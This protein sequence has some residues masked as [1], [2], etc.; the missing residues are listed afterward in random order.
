MDSSRRLHRAAG[1]S[2]VARP[3]PAVFFDKDGTLVV[4]VPYNVDPA[5]IRLAPGAP[6]G[7]PML[8]RLRL[9]LVVISNQSGIGSGR[10]GADALPA[11]SDRL[12][13]LCS[14]L[15]ASLTDCYYCPHAPQADGTPACGC[16][17]PRP[18]MLWAAARRHRIDLSE[19]W[20]VGD[21]LDDIEAAHRAGCRA[22]LIDNG[23]ETVWRDGPGRQPDARVADLHGAACAIVAALRIA[24]H[25]RRERRAA[26]SKAQARRVESSSSLNLR[27]MR[28][29]RPLRV[30]PTRMQSSR[31]AAPAGRP[32]PSLTRHAAAT[33]EANGQ[34]RTFGVAA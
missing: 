14:A 26:V 28:T 3:R 2:G 25:A 21:I 20:F 27:S 12:Q 30:P 18:G 29:V 32:G 34:D 7:L 23:N 15:G 17:K 19:S 22:V 6:E 13:V 5:L 1:R 9:P 24:R 16:R 33:F 10:F 11:V 4:D 8:A 31:L